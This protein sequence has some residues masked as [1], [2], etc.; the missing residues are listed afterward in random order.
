MNEAAGA[1]VVSLSVGSWHLI[2]AT[3]IQLHPNLGPPMRNGSA[4]WRKQILPDHHLVSENMKLIPSR[5]HH[6]LQIAFTVCKTKEKP[7]AI[8]VHERHL[9]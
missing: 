9:A 7:W 6:R 3:E 4:L 2:L 5:S 8:L 1:S